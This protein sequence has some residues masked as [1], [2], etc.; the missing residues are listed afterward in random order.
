[1]MQSS[2]FA[3]VQLALA[4]VREHKLRSFLTVL[5]VIIGTSTIIGVGSVITGLDSS[6]T[7]VLRSF[8]TNTAIV[9]KFPIGFNMHLT[10]EELHRKPLTYENAHAI[11]ERSPDV[12]HVS[13]YVFP[14][15]FGP[16]SHIVIARY[17][18]NAIYEV[19]MGGTEPDF[20]W[21]GQA[22]MKD[23][24]FFTEADNLHHMPVT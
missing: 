14:T 3:T 4:T 5:G 23:G 10:P 2:L 22:E 9:F 1:M 12:D 11:A 6:I 13:A 8:G 20:A 19:D 24:R 18:G 15:S 21:S 16:G 17:K 7:A